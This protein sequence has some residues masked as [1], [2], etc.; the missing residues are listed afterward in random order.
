[1]IGTL[2]AADAGLSGGMARHAPKD[3]LDYSKQ[4]TVKGE[5]SGH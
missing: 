3:R 5:H 4:E 2:A 1:M